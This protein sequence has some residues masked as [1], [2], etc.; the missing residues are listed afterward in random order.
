MNPIKILQITIGVI[1]VE[2]AS[3]AILGGNLESTIVLGYSFGMLLLAV[4]F[5][6][7]IPRLNYDRTNL[8]L[9]V[10]LNIFI[11]GSFINMIEGW[12]FTTTYSNLMPFIIQAFTTLLTVGIES[13]I[14]VYIMPGQGSETIL[15]ELKSHWN[16]LSAGVFSRSL[17]ICGVGY[18]PV[19]FFFGLL[20]SP[21][22]IEY[23]NDPALGLVIPPFS[24]LIPLEILRGFMFVGTL[25]PLV[26]GLKTRRDIFI[27]CAAMLFVQGSLIPLIGDIGLPPQIV[28]YHLVELFCDSTVYG[29]L[30]ARLFTP[31]N[32][33]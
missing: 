10:W 7:L 27:A 26:V 17:I 2:F 31:K 4:Y 21:F 18:L 8:F 23:Y 16:K 30:V 15:S 12:F 20:V 13:G 33:V 25:L 29:Y 14:I 5:D 32:R 24:L 1:L 19:Y 22:V 9:A 28:P 3:R 11:I 6:W